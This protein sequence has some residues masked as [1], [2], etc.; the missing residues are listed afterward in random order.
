MLI[1]Q[2]ASS[3]SAPS[4]SPCWKLSKFSAIEISLLQVH[5]LPLAVPDQTHLSSS[6]L[7]S[8]LTLKASWNSASRGIDCLLLDILSYKYWGIFRSQHTTILRHGYLR[9]TLYSLSRGY[10]RDGIF[11]IGTHS[12][13]RS[14]TPFSFSPVLLFRG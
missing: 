1:A 8:R 4:D 9:L 12:I 14:V 10:P 7:V 5:V 11:R 13:V 2:K 3:R 6:I